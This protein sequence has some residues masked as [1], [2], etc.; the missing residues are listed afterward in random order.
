MRITQNWRWTRHHPIEVRG[1]GTTEVSGGSIIRLARTVGSGSSQHTPSP[2]P[3][4]SQS[5]PFV[6]QSP[7]A[8]GSHPEH[9]HASHS[10]DTP[11][12]LGPTFHDAST[13]PIDRRADARHDARRAQGASS[14]T[15]PVAPD[16]RWR[17]G[18]NGHANAE[19]NE[20]F[21]TPDR[22]RMF[23]ALKRYE[24]Y[25][26]PNPPVDRAPSSSSSIST[27]T[28]SSSTIVE[29]G[30]SQSPQPQA[31]PFPASNGLKLTAEDGTVFYM[32]AAT[33][34]PHIQEYYRLHPDRAR[35]HHRSAQPLRPALRGASR[36]ENR[37]GDG[38]A[39]AP[40]HYNNP[41]STIALCCSATACS[42]RSAFATVPRA[43]TV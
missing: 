25:A 37:E 29:G 1:E 7:Q 22:G 16:D 38:D 17:C 19:A 33:E 34:A 14:P 43:W 40:H 13:T 28:S 5:A 10:S 23:E 41:F 11:P 6:P 15:R 36:N 31:D 2:Q 3:S 4:G 32:M 42:R 8:S 20:A 26:E 12:V 18:A 35:P 27:S 39:G 24:R 9:E 21:G 30:Y